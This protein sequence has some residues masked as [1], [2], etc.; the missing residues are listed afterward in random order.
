MPGE[1]FVHRNIANCVMH[2]DL[3]CLS[4]LQYA[5]EILTQERPTPFR[6]APCI[7]LSPACLCTCCLPLLL[8]WLT[9]AL[10]ILPHP[11][12]QLAAPH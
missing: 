8:G 2:T 11:F 12:S 6:F 1:V 7:P 4:V 10:C 3:N 5:G 9:S